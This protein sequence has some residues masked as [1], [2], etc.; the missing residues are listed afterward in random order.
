MEIKDKYFLILLIIF[1]FSPLL[2]GGAGATSRPDPG[3]SLGRRRH[4]AHALLGGPDR[5]QHF[6]SFF[7]NFF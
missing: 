6:V 3:V 2:P 5:L 4:H 1:I 7:I